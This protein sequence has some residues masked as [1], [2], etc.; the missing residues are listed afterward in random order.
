MPNDRRLIQLWW[1]FKETAQQVKM[2]VMKPKDPN[3]VPEVNSRVGGSKSSELTSGLCAP[4]LT[5]TCI[6]VTYT[7]SVK[8]PKWWLS[9]LRKYYIIMTSTIQLALCISKLHTLLAESK[10]SKIVWKNS[11]SVI[12]LRRLQIE[13][14]NNGYLCLMEL[15][16]YSIQLEIIETYKYMF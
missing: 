11:T 4:Q 6:T 10:I 15:V 16:D 3:S 7:H 14:A 1:G 8:T 12:N 13:K 2:L 5:H 9:F